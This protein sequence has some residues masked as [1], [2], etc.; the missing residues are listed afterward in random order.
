MR[1]P[2]EMQTQFESWLRYK[3]SNLKCALCQSMRWKIGDLLLPMHA[4]QADEPSADEPV[5]AQL[6]CKN[7]AHVMLFDVRRIKSWHEEVVADTSK[8]MIF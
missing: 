1:M 3:C 4:N 7:C 6:V 8:T 2:T 5:M